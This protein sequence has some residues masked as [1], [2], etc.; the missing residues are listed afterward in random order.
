M[1]LDIVPRLHLALIHIPTPFRSV[2]GLSLEGLAL[3]LHQQNRNR[4]IR[5]PVSCLVQLA[6]LV[7]GNDVYIVT[8]NVEK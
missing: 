3:A 7:E 4:R 5:L 2:E 1:S 8:S 6:G